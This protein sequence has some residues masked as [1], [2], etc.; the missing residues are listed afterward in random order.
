MA[1]CLVSLTWFPDVIGPSAV[2]ANA[3]T[4][5]GI[6][7]RVLNF[8]S[9]GLSAVD[10][11]P[12]RRT[13]VTI[14]N[15]DFVT[16]STS[17]SSSGEWQPAPANAANA[18][19]FR[20]SA[21]VPGVLL[22][23]LDFTAPQLKLTKFFANVGTANSIALQPPASV[24]GGHQYFANSFTLRPNET[25]RAVWDDVSLVYRIQSTGSAPLA[26][27]V[28]LDGVYVALDGSNVLKP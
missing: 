6:R 26:D 14:P 19:L 10:N 9:A 17:R 22:T 25:A 13:D 24:L 11:A 7:G 23:G 28:V 21:S 8:V 20:V 1:G 5:V 4:A 3:G 27:R 16:I 15:P 12:R 18:D 2:S